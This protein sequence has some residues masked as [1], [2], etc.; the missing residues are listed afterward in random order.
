MLINMILFCFGFEIYWY[1]VEKS[2]LYYILNLVGVNFLI[3]FKRKEKRDEYKE[4]RKRIRKCI[5]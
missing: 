3:N 1:K 5:I 4:D 2:C